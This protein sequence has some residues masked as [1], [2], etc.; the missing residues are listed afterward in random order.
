VLFRLKSKQ[1]KASEAPRC[2]KGVL[3]LPLAMIRP[4]K[5]AKTGVYWLRKA[6]PQAL[7]PIVG[8]RELVASLETKEP[9]EAR[10]RAR[11][12]AER[13]EAI[14]ERARLGLPPAASDTPCAPVSQDG[15][16]SSVPAARPPC[17]Q[18]LTSASLLAAWDLEQ[19]RS[20]ATLKKYRAAFAQL[21]RVLGFDDIKRITPDD[22]AAFKQA[23]LKQGRD[24]GTVQDDIL[25][26]GT[27]CRWAV[28]NRKLPTNPFEGMAP[29]PKRRGPAARAG[30]SDDEARR[31]LLAA[32]KE[33]GW[34]RWLPW[35]LAFTGCRLSEAAE[36]R[37]QD[38]RRERCH[39]KTGVAEVWIVDVV[40]VAGRDRKTDDFQRMIPIHPALEAE[41]FVAF[42]QEVQRA[43]ADGPLFA[44]LAVASDGSRTTTA[45][46]QHGRWVRKVVGITEPG[47]APAHSWRHRMQDELRKARAHPEVIDAVTG[48]H[49]P[50]NAGDGYGR[51]F[52][53]MPD[54]VFVDLRNIPS[55]LADVAVQ[56]TVPNGADSAAVEIVSN[57]DLLAELEAAMRSWFAGKAREAYSLYAD[58]SY[59]SA[60]VPADAIAADVARNHADVTFADAEWRIERLKADYRDEGLAIGRDAAREVMHRMTSRRVLEKS[61]A[62]DIVAVWCLLALG[63]IEEARQRWA[64]GYRLYRPA[65]PGL[66]GLADRMRPRD[67][68]SVSVAADPI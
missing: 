37:A 21:S 54:E 2:Y 3:Q 48:R 63:E 67:G 28:K 47:K 35:V 51:G 31:I 68:V 46:T 18:P 33:T 10:R 45:Q 4:T 1:I 58:P 14:I 56:A 7:R 24:P 8:K 22:V 50:R 41:G 25:A 43:G 20:A 53:G 23:R 32:R 34:R 39:A 52:R 36:L 59:A 55:P 65:M 9:A 6:V 27:V 12:V 40:P 29:R 66:R 57:G 13:F 15:P 64:A 61:Q 42:A 62:F 16:P 38:V 60:L 11:S 26:C 17:D 30:Y 5:H 44:D 19:Q 49:N